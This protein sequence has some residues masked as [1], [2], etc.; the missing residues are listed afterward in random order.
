MIETKDLRVRMP[1]QLHV[2][3][4]AE[5]AAQDRSMNWLIN[6]A[7]KKM[8]ESASLNLHQR[9]V[10]IVSESKSIFDK[11]EKEGRFLCDKP[12]TMD[13]ALAIAR[14]ESNDL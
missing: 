3:L 6:D 11:Q 5:A 13:E 10:Q 2:K 4:K 8:L 9:A 14:E 7:V 1:E 12:A